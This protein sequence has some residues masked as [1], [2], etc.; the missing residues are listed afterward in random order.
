MAAK[1]LFPLSSGQ[2][3]VY[4]QQMLSFRKA[5]VNICTTM[6]FEEEIDP[7]LMQQAIYL[8]ICRNKSAFTRIRKVDKKN[9]QYFSDASPDKIEVYDYSESTDEELE[10]DI[11]KWS[12]TPF[13]NKSCDTQLYRAKF[14]L[15]PD[16]KYALYLA[17]SHLAF[18]A[19]S[20][21][22][23]ASDILDCYKALRDGTPILPS[24]ANPMATMEAEKS[25]Y[26]S[27]KYKRDEEFWTNMIEN[28]P[29]PTYASFNEFDP[30]KHKE[31]RVK[32]EK[33]GRLGVGTNPF[34]DE[35]KH[36]KRRLDKELV[37]KVN[38]TAKAFSVSPQVIYLLAIRSYISKMRDGLEDISMI[39][40]VARRA[41]LAQKRAGG[42]R[43]IGITF[44]MNIRNA[45][46]F[47]D[48]CLEMQ[49]LQ[50]AYYKHSDYPIMLVTKKFSEKFQTP[51]FTT[52]CSINVTFQPYYVAN[53]P[54]VPVYFT[55]HSNGGSSNT[56]YLTIMALD[57]S[58][59]LVFNY[60]Y[61]TKIYTEEKLDDV[62]RHIEEFLKKA[63]EEPETTL[64]E[65]MKL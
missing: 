43:V 58:G 9:L 36:Y 7:N 47:K 13:P 19:Y 42:T 15:K 8:G 31:Y 32:K 16:G 35:G 22:A 64:V 60:D 25:Y 1:N 10:A 41:T 26:G 17:V 4:Y 54:T 23:M 30:K 20:L 24:K 62:H 21:M 61:Q 18:D 5:I 40:T 12:K 29:E 39:N 53:E 49:N 55:T 2:M 34:I 65:L 6:H 44:R 3:I 59:D 11:E 46:S 51:M 57:N 50:N 52:Y 45:L 33:R 38:E 27:E 14:I 48:A 28:N 56:C 63:T 37:A